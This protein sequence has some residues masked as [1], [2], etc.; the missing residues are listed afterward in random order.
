MQVICPSCRHVVELGEG[1]SAK[2]PNCGD[3]V[4]VPRFA[5]GGSVSSPASGPQAAAAVERPGAW[6]EADPEIPAPSV[7]RAAQVVAFMGGL[8]FCIPFVPQVLGICAALFALMR[9]RLRN[10]RV[11]LAWAGLVL[12]AVA[13]PLWAFVAV[14]AVNR[15]TTARA[16]FPIPARVRSGGEA[17]GKTAALTGEMERIHR[18]ATAYFRDYKRWPDDVEVL[19]GRS[20]PRTFT[21][22]DELT[23]RPV[24]EKQAFSTEWVLIVS[25]VVLYDAD[26]EQLEGPHRLVLRLNGKID[27]LPE[28]DVEELLSSQPLDSDAD[29]S[30]AEQ[31]SE[32]G[33][34]RRTDPP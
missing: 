29:D 15:A 19:V 25:E 3:T 16:L 13:L 2:C 8:L 10:E 26:G 32:E 28:A 22:S 12:S 1:E 17:M 34:R 24:P 27:I 23:Y 14:S 21:M 11:G 31:E 5:G 6:A 20:L 30:T 4:N 9:P 18:A 7:T 33:G